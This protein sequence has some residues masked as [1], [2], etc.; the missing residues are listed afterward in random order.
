MRR[1]IISGGL[2]LTFAVSLTAQKI[3]QSVQVTNDYETRFADFKKSEPDLVLPDSLYAFD[4]SFDYSVFDSPYKGSYEFTPY[5]VEIVPEKGVYD[6]NRLFLMAGAGYTLRP[7]L[8][9]VYSPLMKKNASVSIYNFGKGYYGKKFYDL[10]DKLGVSGHWLMPATGTV[11][12]NA[13]YE[14]IFSGVNE[15]DGAYH[16]TFAGLG[17]VSPDRGGSFFVYGLNVAG[18]YGS[19]SQADG[20]VSQ[21]EVKLDAYL[22]PVLNSKY[23][24]LLDFNFDMMALND[25]RP[26]TEAKIAN[27]AGFRPHMFF[28]WGTFD[29]DLGAKLDVVMSGESTFLPAPSL[30]VALDIPSAA[31]RLAASF[32]GGAKLLSYHGLKSFNHF[33]RYSTHDALYERERY[34]LSLGVQ[35]SV[36][37]Y[38]EYGLKGGYAYYS[39]SPLDSWCGVGFTDYKLAYTDLNMKW[40]S[41]SFRSTLSAQ[42]KYVTESRTAS[43]YLPSAFTADFDFYYMYLKRLEAGIFVKA[44]TSRTDI[45]GA[46]PD[47]PGYAD[48]GLSAE[49]AFNRKWSFW[50]EIGNL[51]CADIQRRPG[52]VESGPYVTLG[53]SLTVK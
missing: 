29:I 22:G 26:A 9:V 48:L 20:T 33:Y 18:R 2:L 12:W 16:S 37:T 35:G 31:M 8:D 50:G 32:E 23:R 40:R 44:A 6:G 5:N 3:N 46:L 17:L 27:L 53:V 42:Y 43:V 1:L 14:G 30:R 4:Y 49:Y 15:Y 28:S 51:L 24:F 19:E 36:G 34:N 41:E 21:G 47:I 10:S 7:R 52:L 39:D 25:S 13:G 38:F 11:T 45:A